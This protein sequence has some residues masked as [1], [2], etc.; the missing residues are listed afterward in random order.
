[1]NRWAT[2]LSAFL[3]FERGAIEVVVTLKFKKRIRALVLRFEGV[4]GRW[5][6]TEFE[7]L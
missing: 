5:L 4:D 7:L 1:M 6:C 3:I 2:W